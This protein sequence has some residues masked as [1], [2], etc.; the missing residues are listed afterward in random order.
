MVA[1]IWRLLLLIQLS[2]SNSS[3]NFYFLSSG[4]PNFLVSKFCSQRQHPLLLSP[5]FIHDKWDPPISDTSFFFLFLFF[6]FFF[7]FSFMYF[8]FLFPC[9]IV[10]ISRLCHFTPTSV[11]AAASP[12]V[13]LVAHVAQWRE[14]GAKPAPDARIGS[15]RAGLSSHKSSREDGAR[16]WMASELGEVLAGWAAELQEVTLGFG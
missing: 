14:Q 5:F 15:A 9:S 4:C 3:N 10:S 12:V 13:V 2:H 16:A 1:C 11:H 8:F 7:F 6:F